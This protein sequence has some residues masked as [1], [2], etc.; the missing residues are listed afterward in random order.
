M[1]ANSSCCQ[2]CEAIS[3]NTLNTLSVTYIKNPQKVYGQLKSYVD[4][5]ADYR[6]RNDSDLKSANIELKTIHLAIPE[7]T[8]PAQWRYLHE[9]IIYG[10]ERGVRIVITRIRE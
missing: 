7:Y 5:V 10:K 6:P 3:D 4:D 8:S 9:G 1:A 2:I